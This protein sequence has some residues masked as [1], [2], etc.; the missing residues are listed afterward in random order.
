[1][2]Q[3]V[4]LRSHVPFVQWN[5]KR[6]QSNR[7]YFTEHIF[8]HILLGVF[9]SVHSR[10]LNVNIEALWFFR[11]SFQNTM[12]IHLKYVLLLVTFAVADKQIKLEDIE[13]DNLISERRVNRDEE[14][15]KIGQNQ[16]LNAPINVQPQYEVILECFY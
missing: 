4:I 9:N 10:H 16:H 6:S 12:K 11:F 15:V 2:K 5:Y 14:V 1:M 8:V 3:S 7:K 13:R